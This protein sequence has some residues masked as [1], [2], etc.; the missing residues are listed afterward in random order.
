MI[1]GVFIA[2]A[3]L[4]RGCNRSRFGDTHSFQCKSTIQ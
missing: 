2:T 1:G 4:A 3:D